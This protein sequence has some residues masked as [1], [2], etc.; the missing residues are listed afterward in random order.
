[1]LNLSKPVSKPVHWVIVTAPFNFVLQLFQMLFT[2]HMVL[3]V[4]GNKVKIGQREGLS[5]CK[6]IAY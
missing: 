5:S 2:D 3:V 1:M 6:E 4:D